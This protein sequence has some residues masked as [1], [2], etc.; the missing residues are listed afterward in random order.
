MLNHQT[1]QA[2]AMKLVDLIKGRGPLPVGYAAKVLGLPTTSVRS[3]LDELQNRGVVRLYTEDDEDMVKVQ[4]ENG[5]TA[6]V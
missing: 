5:R 4:L 1:S 2:V 6:A 3:Y